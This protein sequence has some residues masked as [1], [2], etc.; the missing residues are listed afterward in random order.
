MMQWWADYLEGLGTDSNV[1]P[2]SKAANVWTLTF[3]NNQPPS[4]GG[5]I[6]V[7]EWSTEV[8]ASA[9]NCIEALVN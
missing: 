8:I 3:D 9:I 2:F 4:E 1:I 5:V 7:L 6:T